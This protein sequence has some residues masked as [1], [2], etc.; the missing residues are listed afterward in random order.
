[1]KH[2]NPPRRASQI[3]YS[4]KHLHIPGEGGAL[5]SFPY[6]HVGAVVVSDDEVEVGVS[7]YSEELFHV[8]DQLLHPASLVFY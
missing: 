2:S 5:Q 7:S 3:K 4:A 8:R 6:I 1:M